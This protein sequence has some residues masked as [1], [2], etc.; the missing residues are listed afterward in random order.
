MGTFFVYILKSSFCLA[1][2]YLFYK[3]LLSRETFHR[4][5]RVALLGL[6]LLS[7]I[8]PLIEVTMK[9]PVEMDNPFLA[10]ED[11]LLMAEAGSAEATDVVMRPLIGWREALLLIYIAGIV[12]FL[13]RNVWSLARLAGLL[14]GCN[15]IRLEGGIVMFVHHREMAPFS[16]MKYIVVSE[17]DK[18][19]SGQ[20]IVTHETA[21]IR[22]GHSWDLLL[23][24]VCV[25]FQWFN[26]AA[27]LLKQELQFIHE[28]E[29]D[30]WVLKQGIDAKE[31]QLL[32]IK[33][34]V[35]ARLY[36][37]ANSLNHS[38]L[39]KRIAMMIKKKSNPWA[40]MKYL[41]VLPLA[42]V[43]VVAFAR[44]EVSNQLDEISSVKV[45][46]LTSVVKANEVK[47][48]ENVSEEKGTL[49]GQVL[50]KE[51]GKPIIGAAV[52]VKGTTNGTVTDFDGNFT[53][54]VSKGDVV[55]IAY[56]GVKTAEVT[57]SATPEKDVKSS[58][59]VYLE[60]EP[61]TAKENEVVVVGYGKEDKG[62]YPPVF[63]VVEE[64]PEYPGGMP[65]LMKYLAMNLRYPADA[66]E[67]GIQGRVIVQFVVE[68]D[69]S[70]SNFQ[71]MRGIHPLLDAEAI[72]ALSGMA[73]W[74]PG[75][76]KGVAV[77]VKYTL[78]VN[79]S[80]QGQKP[81]ED[82]AVRIKADK[83]VPMGTITEVKQFLRGGDVTNV[84]YE[85]NEDTSKESQSEPLVVVDGEVKGTSSEALSSVNPKDVESISVLNGKNAMEKYGKKAKAGVII[86]TTKK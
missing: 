83:D 1:L 50:S 18:R 67:K 40:R 75:K 60:K 46:D 6:M 62:N 4:F 52:I 45:S 74:T 13:I 51:T 2:F 53:L 77:R 86:I 7:C 29:A 47:S 42:T 39:K 73:K 32:L 61:E 79:F 19:E 3:L 23:A 30:E 21:H 56:V 71:V 64:A 37:I 11:L 84:N 55:T 26:P 78:P 66:H 15:K 25:F 28:F 10:L 65:E 24:D 22:N 69:G 43:T 27:W 41:Y 35:G 48:V 82:N 72:R 70:V 59:T 38:S 16:W 14:K 33:K 36:S 54:S 20:A 76:Q 63:N 17:T 68:R 31:Y 85:V 57:I 5:N 81:Q 12:F 8:V 44:P 58:V 49:K 34:A 9:Q 80:L